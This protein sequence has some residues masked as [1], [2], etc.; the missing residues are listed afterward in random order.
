VGLLATSAAFAWHAEGYVRCDG[1]RNAQLDGQDIGIEGAKVLVR[2]LAGNFETNALTDADGRYEV[3]LPDYGDTYR[4]SLDSASLPADAIVVVPPGG[5]A[6]V[7]N[8]DQSIPRVDFL[9]QSDT[10]QPGQC[11]LTGG[12]TKWDNIL[13]A[14]TAEK[15]TKHNFGGNVHPGCSATAGAGGSWN[16]IDR[17]TKLHFHGTTIPNVVCGNVPGIPPGSTSPKT[18]FNYIEFWGTGWV[19]GVQGNKTDLPLVYF[20]ARAE[21]RNEPGSRGAAAGSMVDRYFLRVYTDPANPVASTLI[22]VDT[23]AG[24]SEIDATPITTGNMQIHV[25]SCDDPPLQ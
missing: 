18:P 12:G 2:N 20:Y 21:D 14:F 24:G 22:L 17:S 25:S 11:W 23:N 8:F 15:G 5:V 10:C 6:E 1:N 9:V 13:N 4:I 3:G 19:K 7:S 16:H